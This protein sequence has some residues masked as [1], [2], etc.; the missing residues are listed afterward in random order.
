MKDE[1]VMQWP[2]GGHWQDVLRAD[3]QELRTCNE[4][5]T[6]KRSKSRKGQRSKINVRKTGKVDL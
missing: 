1:I 4:L 6:M 5:P 3:N 2:L